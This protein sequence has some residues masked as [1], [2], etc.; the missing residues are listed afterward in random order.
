MLTLMIVSALFYFKFIPEQIRI[1]SLWSGST[2]FSSRTFPNLLVLTLFG[3]SSIGF[4]RALW[5]LRQIKT[6][7]AGERPERRPFTPAGVVNF[8]TPVI[9]LGIILLYCVLFKSIGY[10]WASVLVPPVLLLVLNCR[11]W[12]YYAVVYAFSAILYVIFK[13][14]LLV[15][16]P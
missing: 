16:L 9:V 11:R 1:S 8:L 15:P 3:V 13:L 7:T 14:V 6:G 10:I 12:Q 5:Q 2:S 4:L